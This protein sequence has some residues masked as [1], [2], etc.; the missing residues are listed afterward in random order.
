MIERTDRTVV[1]AQFGD[2][3]ENHRANNSLI[4]ARAPTTGATFATAANSTIARCAAVRDPRTVRVAYRLRPDAGSVPKKTRSSQQP[5]PRSRIDP[6][7][8]RPF[9]PPDHPL[10]HLTDRSPPELQMGK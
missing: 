6:D 1:G 9:D 4:N 8:A 3:T 7:M 2:A 5:T 10:E